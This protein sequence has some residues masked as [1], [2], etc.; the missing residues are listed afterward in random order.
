VGAGL[1]SG[2]RSAATTTETESETAG[3]AD[4]AD[5]DDDDDLRYEESGD[6]ETD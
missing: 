6:E 3:D 5:D 2:D 1:R 4:D